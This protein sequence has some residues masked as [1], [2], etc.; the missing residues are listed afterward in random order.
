MTAVRPVIADMPTIQLR[1]FREMRKRPSYS[2]RRNT[3]RTTIVKTLHEDFEG[4]L[5][6]MNE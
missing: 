5:D 1:I 6:L 2:L 4:H 3:G